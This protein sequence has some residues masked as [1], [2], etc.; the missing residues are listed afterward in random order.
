MKYGNT[1]KRNLTGSLRAAATAAC[2]FRMHICNMGGVEPPA[3]LSDT[4]LTLC[5]HIH[6]RDACC[7]G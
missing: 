5:I 3:I 7:A 1:A 2:F 6:L 4:S